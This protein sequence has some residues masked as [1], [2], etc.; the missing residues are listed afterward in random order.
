MPKYDVGYTT[1][2]NQH[3]AALSA[4]RSNSEFTDKPPTT[5]SSLAPTHPSGASAF[6]LAYAENT[7]VFDLIVAEL[8]SKLSASAAAAKLRGG[9]DVGQVP[10]MPIEGMK[11]GTSGLR[12]KVRVRVRIMTVGSEETHTASCRVAFFRPPPRACFL[13][14]ARHFIMVRC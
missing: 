5:R 14:M 13:L 6:P 3:T 1:Y 12:K 2:P 7:Q 4:V 10:T 8:D 11:P 9:G